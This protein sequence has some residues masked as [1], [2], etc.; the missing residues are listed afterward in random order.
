MEE[1]MSRS[2]H[3][4]VQHVFTL[5][6]EGGYKLQG[7]YEDDKN[8]YTAEEFIMYHKGQTYLMNIPEGQEVLM[9]MVPD[10]REFTIGFDHVT[11]TVFLDVV[12]DE[13]MNRDSKEIFYLA[14]MEDKETT[15]KK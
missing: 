13:F 1:K 2:T 9:F 10:D 5:D 3:T 7:D 15:D 14:L 4:A 8:F 11:D 6:P 12:G